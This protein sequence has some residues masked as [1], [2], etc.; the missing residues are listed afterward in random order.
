MGLAGDLC[1]NQRDTIIDRLGLRETEQVSLA[2][3]SDPDGAPVGSLRV[4]HGG[5]GC[6]VSKAVYIG[7]TVDA[8]GLDSHM[9]FA[10]G[11]PESLLPHF[12]VDS[13]Q[14]G[15]GYAFHL[16]LIARVELGVN[17]AYMDEVY[18]PLTEVAEAARS[19]PG[20]GAAHL[21][22]RQYALMS[23]WMVVQRADEAAFAKIAEHVA[24]YR[25]RWLALADGGISA[26]VDL[27]PAA[28]AARDRR[29]RAGLFNPD[30]DPVWAQVSR[31]VGAETSERLRRTLEEQ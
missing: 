11:R 18:G 26:A 17:I 30:V 14:A 1:G 19:V 10:F 8:I 7:L 24:A 6:P 28:I 27:D 21:T 2:S 9:L 3:A 13:V 15:P 5:D 16:D 23:P 29:H 25:D 31:L 12:T 22:M 20:L 4:F